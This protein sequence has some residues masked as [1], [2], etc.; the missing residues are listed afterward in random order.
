LN[1]VGAVIRKHWRLIT[2]IISLIIFVWLIW[3]FISVVLP[4]IIGLIIAY[5]L[6]PIVRW[7]E[8]H[9]PGG[10]KH[11]GA[12]RIS[13]IIGVYFIALII[14]AGMVFYAFTV[15]SSSTSRLWENLPQLISGIVA[16]IQDFMAKIRLEM[17]ASMLKQ[18]DQSIADAGVSVVSALRSGLGG[19]FSMI[20]ASA[21]LFLGFLS[22]PLIVF[23]MLK[24]W[25]KLRDGFFGSIPSWASEHAKNVAGI[26]ERVLG[27]YIR[28]QF[29]MSMVI[30]ILVFIMLT[31]MK[32]EF[33]PALAVW[34]A[35]MESIPLL[36][37]W[38]SI[39]AGVAIALA[40]EPS[41]AV[42]LLLGYV[43]IQQIENNVLVP[44]IQGSVMKMNPIFIIL[45]SLVGAYL[46][47]LVGFIIA[48]P[49]VVTVIELS[50]YFLRL[51]RQKEP[52]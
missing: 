15:V 49:A 18:Y 3:Q 19:G 29:I 27:R 5:L 40:T 22:L 13:I 11:P 31:V 44:R 46:A 1:S 9:L 20:T 17:P 35:L 34:A 45:V 48:V 30:G 8:K 14:I 25:D 12:K 4:F 21:G 39:G 36:G 52:E 7:L 6:L 47:G 33:A 23:F 28:G 2:F 16:W 38:L 51:S 42:W 32:I 41:K 24:D 37:V 50:K 43:I 26:L 10:K